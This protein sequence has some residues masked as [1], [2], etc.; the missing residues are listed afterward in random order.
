MINIDE[1][2]VKIY[3]QNK[4]VGWWDDLDRCIYETLQLVSTEF[5]LQYSPLLNGVALKP[6]T[7]NLKGSKN[8]KLR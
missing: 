1:Q 2:S 6:I 8:E 7:G 3:Q 5:S 4:A